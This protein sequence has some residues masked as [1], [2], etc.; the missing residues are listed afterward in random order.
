MP[1]IPKR[2]D[3]LHDKRPSRLEGLTQ[4]AV[5]NPYY[6]QPEPNPDW[7]P[8]AMQWYESLPKSGQSHYY[9]ASDW[10]TAVMCADLISREFH[11]ADDPESK[12]GIS[13]MMIHEIFTQAG[14]LLTTEGERRRLRL[15]LIRAE[16]NDDSEE[17]VTALEQYKQYAKGG[18]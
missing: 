11:R 13:P 18:K 15:E 12:K 2:S 1:P 4:L 8:I 10:A 7:H 6:E 3:Q 5:N 9:Q 16:K 14:N 17:V